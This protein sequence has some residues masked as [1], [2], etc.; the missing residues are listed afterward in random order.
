M[1]EF[2]HSFS[3]LKLN[4]TEIGLFSGII[5]ST[6]GMILYHVYYLADFCIEIS[7]HCNIQI[8]IQLN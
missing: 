6:A 5:L 7:V 8:E 3:Q 2:A 1:F 4:D